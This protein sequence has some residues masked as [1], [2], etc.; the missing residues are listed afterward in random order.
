MFGLGGDDSIVADSRN[1]AAGLGELGQNNITQHWKSIAASCAT[2]LPSTPAMSSAPPA[3]NR[4]R[5][6]AAW[7]ET[8]DASEDYWTPSACM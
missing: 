5:P 2:R 1:C 3:V 8:N 7:I 4:V 6:A